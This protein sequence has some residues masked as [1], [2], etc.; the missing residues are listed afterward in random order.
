MRRWQFLAGALLLAV[1]T[2][3]ASCQPT[4]SSDAGTP[5]VYML[6]FENAGG[7]QGAQANIQPGGSLTVAKSFL[8]ATKANIRIYG[9]EKPGITTLVVT[10]SASGRC[11]TDITPEGQVFTAP[12]PLTATLPTLTEKAPAGQVQNFLAASLDNAL[13][14]KISCGTHI[15]NGMSRKLEFFLDSGTWKIHAEASNC[16]G[17]KGIGDFTIVMK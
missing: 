12:S 15:Y 5:T 10:G 17:G 9:E 2:T 7:Q 11:S 1:T 3:A 8:G 13:A 6:A 4:P 14:G 16:C